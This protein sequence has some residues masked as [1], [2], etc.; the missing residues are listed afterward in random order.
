MWDEAPTKIATISKG[1]DA[2]LCGVMEVETPF[3]WTNFP[4]T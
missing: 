3:S 2:M 1:I 4:T